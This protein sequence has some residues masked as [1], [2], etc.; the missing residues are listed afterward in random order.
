MKNENFASRHFFEKYKF[1]IIKFWD[2]CGS[3]R[4]VVGKFREME[5][6]ERSY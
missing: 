3:A 6:I 5:Y 4:G 2:V 1:P